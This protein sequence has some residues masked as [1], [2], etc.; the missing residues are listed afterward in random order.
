MD[1]LELKGHWNVLKGKLKQT[2][3]ELTD[4]DLRYEEGREDELLGRIQKK[5]GQTK[6]QLTKWLRHQTEASHKANR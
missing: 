2:F 3:G 6:E 4:D 1:K 5:T